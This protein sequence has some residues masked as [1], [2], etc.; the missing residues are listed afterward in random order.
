MKH[1]KLILISGMSG[2]GKS[3]ASQQL[4]KQYER[5]SI[6]QL[7][8]HE[9]IANHPIRE[10]EFEIGDR[11]TEEGMA[12]NIADMYERWTRLVDEI[13]KSS[14]VYIMEGCLYQNIVRYFFPQIF[15]APFFR[16]PTKDKV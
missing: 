13:D 16:Y 15:I 12:Q 2:A 9:E 7:W 10:G 8:L 1:S 6:E 3:T 14:R 4:A 5:N 11:L